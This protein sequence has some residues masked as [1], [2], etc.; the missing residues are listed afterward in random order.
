[1]WNIIVKLFL[2]NPVL[3]SSAI[4]RKRKQ[5]SG[6]EHEDK[7]FQNFRKIICKSFYIRKE[8]LTATKYNTQV[9][10]LNN[11]QW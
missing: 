1:M 6:H 5:A 8:H 3:C 7:Q 9:P 4:A 2:K 11:F 10:G